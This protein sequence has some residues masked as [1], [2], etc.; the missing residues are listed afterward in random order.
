ML[1]STQNQTQSPFALS[2]TQVAEQLVAISGLRSGYIQ[3]ATREPFSHYEQLPISLFEAAKAWAAI[4]ERQGAPRVYW[5][6]LS[7]VVTHLHIHLYPRWPEDTRKGITLFEGRE[8]TPQPPW[9]EE[10][11]KALTDWANRYGVYVKPG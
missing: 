11:V 10:V 8:K 9:S 4:L 3:L 1:H 6:T 5:I 2:D 7:E